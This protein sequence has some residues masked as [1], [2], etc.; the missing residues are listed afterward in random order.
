MLM[1]FKIILLFFCVLPLSALCGD[2]LLDSWKARITLL[3]AGFLNAAFDFTRSI[4]DHP[5]DDENA[6]LPEVMPSEEPVEIVEIP[7]VVSPEVTEVVNAS[8]EVIILPQ[9]PYERRYLP[10]GIDVHDEWAR[11]VTLPTTD[12]NCAAFGIYGRNDVTRPEIVANLIEA[13]RGNGD[14]AIHIRTLVAPEILGYLVDAPTDEIR[15][16]RM[17]LLAP[18]DTIFN[19]LN[20]AWTNNDNEQLLKVLR[21]QQ[22]FQNYL[23]NVVGRRLGDSEEDSYP[24]LTLI[25]D[26]ENLLGVIA[27]IAAQQRVT[28]LNI[29]QRI[30]GQ[31][32]RLGT[33]NP[34]LPLTPGIQ[35]RVVDLIHTT[36]DSL[37]HPDAL[38]HFNLLERCGTFYPVC[39]IQTLKDDPALYL[40][41]WTVE[42]D[43][44][45]AFVIAH[46][47]V[48]RWIAKLGLMCESSLHN[49]DGRN[50][51]AEI[52][53]LEIRNL[54]LENAIDKQIHFQPEINAQIVTRR[55]AQSLKQFRDLATGL[56]A[57]TITLFPESILNKPLHKCN[58]QLHPVFTSLGVIIDMLASLQLM[59]PTAQR[60]QLLIL[61]IDKTVHLYL[62]ELKNRKNIFHQ[63]GILLT[64][65]RDYQNVFQAFQQHKL[66]EKNMSV[67]EAKLK[68]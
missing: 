49:L 19:I 36:A 48:K 27:A 42:N 6:A 47:N 65:V 58:K 67:E 31:I 54:P 51:V 3:G 25:R 43:D 12:N 62:E 15:Q 39:L 52:A 5:T 29:H 57:C 11:E 59:T 60:V 44:V 26:G 63:N 33:Y 37:N 24:E 56:R 13:A 18:N 68:L 40:Q 64:R 32:I 10:N 34:H 53:F 61:I 21:N 7:E 22:I 4:W 55:W 1:I 8:E 16:E 30:N 28:T 41:T 23:N 9:E 38:N 20:T 14:F 17:R 66:L 2:D 50:N 46:E 35:N 45:T